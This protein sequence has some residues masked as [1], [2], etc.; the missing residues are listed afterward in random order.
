MKVE[1]HG[2]QVF[3][4]HGVTEV[5]Q[6]EGQVFLFDISLW[7]NSEPEEDELEHTIDYR[8]V[9]ACVREVSE[10]RRVQLLETL[11][12]DIADALIERFAISRVRVCARKTQVKLDPPVE[13]SAVTVE[14]P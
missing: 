7:L 1:L 13:Y 11:S 9:G 6:R 8:D 10:A 12:A 4:H 5:E 3:G 14:R 2:L